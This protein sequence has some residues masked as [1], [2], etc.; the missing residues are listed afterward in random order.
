MSIYICI[1]AYIQLIIYNYTTIYQVFLNISYNM[2]FSLFS[3]K[4]Q[5]DKKSEQMSEHEKEDLFQKKQSVIY[6]LLKEYNK[7]QESSVSNKMAK[8]GEIS[9]RYCMTSVTYVRSDK[10]VL[11]LSMILNIY[12]EIYYF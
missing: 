5:K 4:L 12:V 9:S 11:I 2:I 8:H 10:L 3:N 6:N 1:C 7:G